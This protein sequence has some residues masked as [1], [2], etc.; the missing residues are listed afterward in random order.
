MTLEEKKQ[1]RASMSQEELNNLKPMLDPD[2]FPVYN[3]YFIMVM[4]DGLPWC[5]PT[6]EDMNE[7][8]EFPSPKSFFNGQIKDKPITKE[9]AIKL[10]LA[11]KKSLEES[12]KK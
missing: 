7:N 5:E 9:Q 6:K 12:E 1:R 8:F 10:A 2:G 3:E 4:E 11:Y